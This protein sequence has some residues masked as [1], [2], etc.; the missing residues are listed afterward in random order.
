MLNRKR[1]VPALTLLFL[2]ITAATLYAMGGVNAVKLQELIKRSGSAAPIIFVLVYIVATMFIL[3]STALNLLGGALFGPFFGV[4]W[5]STGSIISAVL[6][7]IFTRTTWGKAVAARLHKRWPSLEKEIS[8]GGRYYIF[9]MRLLPI[10]PY[11]LISYGAGLTT[12]RFRDYMLGTVP[13]TV[14]GI[15]PIVMI[16]SSGVRVMKTGDALPLM[17][18]LGATGLLVFIATRYRNQRLDSEKSV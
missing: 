12:L 5:T 8:R 16:G 7:F 18:A 6:S 3:P 17:L 14:L 9:A 13:G 15:L 4:L 2:L 11:G 10:F 1:I